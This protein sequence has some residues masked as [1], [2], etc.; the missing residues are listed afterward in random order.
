LQCVLQD[1]EGVR[2]I[3]NQVIVIS[4]QGLSGSSD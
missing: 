2:S 3:D 1:V 4:G